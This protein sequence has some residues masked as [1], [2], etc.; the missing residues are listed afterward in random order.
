MDRGGGGNGV[1]SSTGVIS[2]GPQHLVKP[3]L[4]LPSPHIAVINSH[5]RQGKPHNANLF[6]LEFKLFLP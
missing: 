4:L 3:R 2:G 6:Q 5:E 1:G